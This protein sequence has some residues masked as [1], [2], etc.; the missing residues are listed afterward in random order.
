[1]YHNPATLWS[2]VNSRF[3]TIVGENRYNSWIKNSKPLILDEDEIVVC[4]ESTYIKNKIDHPYKEMFTN[5]VRN[6]TNRNTKVTFIVDDT[7]FINS[8]LHAS[9]NSSSST[10]ITTPRQ[11]AMT[12]DNFIVGSGNKLAY[13]AAMHISES[14]KPNFNTL[15]I[16]GQTGLGKTHLINSI[17][18]HFACNSTKV[19]VIS[20]SCKNFVREYV[21]SLRSSKIEAFRQKYR[22]A[23]V[24]LVDDIHLLANKKETQVEFLH[25][26]CSLAERNKKIIITSEMHPKHIDEFN[27]N[28][29][30]RLENA[31]ETPVK[32]P[33]YETRVK[34]LKARGVDI[35]VDSLE[36]IARNI[37]TNYKDILICLSNLIKYN[38]PTLITS[39]AVVADFICNWGEKLSLED[40]ARVTATTFGI[41]MNDI[42]SGKKN[43][44][45]ASARQA[46]FYLSHKLTSEPL[47]KIGRYFGNRDHSTVLFAY[48]K[49]SMNKGDGQIKRT[50]EKIEKEL[51]H[52]NR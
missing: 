51:E 40:I 34:F 44:T 6:I 37:N 33:D 20:L 8:K 29:T 46:C 30:A 47:A 36:Y 28:I 7:I 38:N 4:F 14:Q 35:P 19:N 9:N 3:S 49:I 1:M 12:F 52:L 18:T 22:S 50:V 41:K 13:Y 10:Y 48:K 26:L 16:T 25:T 32:N 23:D 21:Y 5:C 42:F 15:L 2:K 31:I 45:V 43:K 39:K 24:L 17:N 27:K 11:P